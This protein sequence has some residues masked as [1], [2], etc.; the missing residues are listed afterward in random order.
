MGFGR[1]GR[2][3][4]GGAHEGSG[5]RRTAARHHVTRLGASDA[6]HQISRSQRRPIR[7]PREAL[8]QA[9]GARASL[10]GAHQ[11][12]VRMMRRGAAAGAR[13][14]RGTRRQSRRVMR[15]RRVVAV[16]RVGAMRDSGVRQPRGRRERDGHHQHPEDP[17]R[18]SSSHD[19][20]ARA[21]GDVPGGA[22]LAPTSNNAA[23]REAHIKEP[24][25]REGPSGDAD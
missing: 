9:G 23:G 15:A 10:T 4:A 1:S 8:G 25:N 21:P 13:E 20:P 5:A 14:A 2:E 12:R 24:S 6:L 11:R 22:R 7:R 18:K 17:R 19:R 16:M 3:G